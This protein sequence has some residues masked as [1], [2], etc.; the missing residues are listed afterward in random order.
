MPAQAPQ[1]RWDDA[2]HVSVEGCEAASPSATVL[3]RALTP[4]VLE[5]VR[6]TDAEAARGPGWVLLPSQGQVSS[7]SKQTPPGSA[8]P[9]SAPAAS[10]LLRRDRGTP[11]HSPGLLFQA[12]ALRCGA[13]RQGDSQG[14]F[15]GAPGRVLT[16][17]PHRR[18]VPTAAPLPT[19]FTFDS[20]G[21]KRGDLQI[22]SSAYLIE[23][24]G[25][26]NCQDEF[27]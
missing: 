2:R 7:G 25:T 13:G 16:P 17:L 18:W 8:G 21:L 15:S 20:D 14:Q 9:A 12:H 24:V 27:Y 23:S 1:S 26:V 4:R 3:S 6:S 19:G 11:A 10:H 5:S 22:I